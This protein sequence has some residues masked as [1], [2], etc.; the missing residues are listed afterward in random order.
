MSAY[1]FR[2]HASFTSMP[3][4]KVRNILTKSS[5]ETLT[6]SS[7]RTVD[8]SIERRINSNG[9]RYFTIAPRRPCVKSDDG[10]YT[11]ALIAIP[12]PEWNNLMG[13]FARA[14]KRPILLCNRLDHRRAKQGIPA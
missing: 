13:F 12:R 9:G 5:Y 10:A 6:R 2:Y 7:P 11:C 14:A 8:I 4:I 3:P 1:V